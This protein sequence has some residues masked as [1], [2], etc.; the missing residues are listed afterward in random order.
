MRTLRRAGA[1]AVLLLLEGLGEA[2][3]GVVAGH[4]GVFDE[5]N[6]QNVSGDGPTEKW[7]LKK[8]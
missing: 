2:E 1:V 6:F 8:K 4:Q 5:K 3:P 7:Q